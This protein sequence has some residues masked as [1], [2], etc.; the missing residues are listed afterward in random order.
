MKIKSSIIKEYL[1]SQNLEK[2][3]LPERFD[4]IVD[5]KNLLNRYYKEEIPKI[6]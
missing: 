1:N 2:D 5:G 4:L 6:Q 3:N